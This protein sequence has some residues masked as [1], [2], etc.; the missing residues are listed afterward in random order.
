[1]FLKERLIIY[2]QKKLLTALFTI[3]VELSIKILRFLRNEALKA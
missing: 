3:R 2:K 1:M